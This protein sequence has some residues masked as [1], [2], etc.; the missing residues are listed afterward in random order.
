[1]SKKKKT[2][3]SSIAVEASGAPVRSA[4]VR[5][6]YEGKVLK[7]GL[8]PEARAGSR[9]VALIPIGLALVVSI[10]TLWNDFASDDERQV[11]NNE[12]IKTLANI[13]H[14]FTSS[15]WAFM[16]GDI[17]FTADSYFRPMFTS[18]FAINYAIF[19]TEA[20]GWHLV[21]VTIHAGVTALVFF[22]IKEVSDRKGTALIAT[23]LFAVH[24]VHAESVAWVS[25]VTDPLMSL[26]LLLAF[27]F[28]L[29]YRKRGGGYRLGLAI[30][31]YFFALLSKE[32]AIA[33]LPIIAY[34][35]L[36]YFK[37]SLSLKRRT[38]RLAGLAG[39]F[40]LPTLFY[41]LMRTHAL[42]SLLFGGPPRNPLVPI[43][44]TIPLV[45]L[46]YVGLVS[47]PYRYNYQHYTALVESGTSLSFIVPCFLLGVLAIAFVWVRSRDFTFSAVWFMV[48]LAPALGVLRQLEPAYLVQ[49]RYLYLPSVGAC[50][51]AALGIEWLAARIRLAGRAEIAAA[52]ITAVLVIGLGAVSFRQNMVWRD[53]IALY[54]HCVSVNP[55]SSPSHTVLSRI[56]FDAGRLREAEAEAREALGL[57]R[58]NL[59]AY[60][61]LSF[62][63]RSSGKLDK[64]IEYLE[65]GVSS[66]SE[67]PITRYDLA[68]TYLNLG[69]LYE[70][71]KLFDRAEAGLLKSISISPRPV[72][73]YHAGQFYYDQNRFEDARSMFEKTA[74]N[75]PLWFSPI[76][77]KL[78]MVYEKLERMEQAKVEY[79][80][81]LEFAPPGSPDIKS[82]QAHLS[83]LRRKAP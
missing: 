82:V 6:R 27:Y 11:L 14:A 3:R 36:G 32:T 51:A 48:T 25:G 17:V 63:A 10:N 64:A 1:V 12:F 71:Q 49:E 33:L 39:L 34:C 19:G 8:A 20:W 13:P 43:I 59:A 57:D 83:Q 67:S 46:K 15:V 35:E 41:L 40:A 58:N 65:Q 72:A 18:L 23:S 54:R 52:S 75:V 7:P 5:R 28:Y 45:A 55:L 81:F 29:R 70:Q 44:A 56:Y 47:I 80:K 62:Y 53:S 26:F 30:L 42:G 38:V 61:S 66:V 77:I 50:F 68:T 4:A 2:G 21:N 24:P 9:L 60:M 79:E 31:F 37:A 22:V 78:G 76:H 73:W 16:G 69:L 74:A